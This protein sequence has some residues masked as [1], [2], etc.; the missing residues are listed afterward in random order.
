MGAVSAAGVGAT[1]AVSKGHSVC[2]LLWRLCVFWACWVVCRSDAAAVIFCLPAAGRHLR[3]L[4]WDLDVGFTYREG[5][6]LH[7]ITCVR[8]GGGRGNR[9]L[10]ARVCAGVCARVCDVYVCV[11]VGGWVGGQLRG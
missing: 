10:S 8:V 3:W 1:Q 11:C 5:L 6:T 7:R 2:G 9:P 4:E